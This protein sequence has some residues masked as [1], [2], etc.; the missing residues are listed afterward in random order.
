MSRNLWQRVAANLASSEASQGSAETALWWTLSESVSP[1]TLAGRLT[2]PADNRAR[3]LVA[4]GDAEMT[5]DLDDLETFLDG[6]RNPHLVPAWLAWSA[7]SHRLIDFEEAEERELEGLTSHG[8]TP[9]GVDRVL[10]AAHRVNVREAILSG[11]LQP[12]FDA[13][14]ELVH[15]AAASIGAANAQRAAES[16]D[17]ATLA[18]AT[19]LRRGAVEEILATGLR[20][21]AAEAAISELQFLVDTLDAEDWRLLRGYL[22][23]EV[24][25]GIQ[26]FDLDAFSEEGSQEGQP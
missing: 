5:E 20:S 10:A 9:D 22:R 3:F 17:A 13:L 4:A 14:I 24:A 15:E 12:A 26:V 23:S 19:S 6:A 11:E 18:D 1:T 21:P 8:L 16:G 25:P 7:F 2:D